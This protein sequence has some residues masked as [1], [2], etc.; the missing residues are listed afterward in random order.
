MTTTKIDSSTQ[1]KQ[2]PSTP[3]WALDH[4]TES[5]TSFQNL[6]NIVQV[7]ERG[8]SMLRGA[9]GFVS[10]LAAINKYKVEYH[11]ADP[12]NP[13]ETQKRLIQA[14]KEAELAQ[15]EVEKEFPV[16]HGFAVVALWALL[17]HFVK[18]LVALWLLHRR[19]AVSCPA[20]QKI[21]IRLG[22]YLQMRKV[23][24]ANFLVEMLEQELASPLKRGANRFLSLLE[25]F[26]LA[27]S[28][29]DRCSKDL[30][31]LQ[32]VRN[33]FAHR[34]GCAD[35]KLRKDCPWL[36]LKLNQ[37]VCI[38]G[39]M[40]ERYQT[41]SVEFIVTILHHFGD[42][43]GVDFRHPPTEKSEQAPKH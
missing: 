6:V 16:L 27:T 33:V 19:H 29:T 14:E 7:S 4:F 26:D 31:E 22:D 36:K 15:S 43:Y 8:I 24:Q 5:L 13:L 37:P 10:A 20:L 34:A 32:Q 41:A 12:E 3:S 2:N 39:E 21:R 35:N 18:R 25:P 17:E 38:S 28:L 30:F 42:I 9:P 1:R 23:E 11:G 40:F